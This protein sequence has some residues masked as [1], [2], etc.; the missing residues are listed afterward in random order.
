[1]VV[2]NDVDRTQRE[3]RIKRLYAD[4]GDFDVLDDQYWELYLRAIKDQ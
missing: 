4:S 2:A 3:P 1:M